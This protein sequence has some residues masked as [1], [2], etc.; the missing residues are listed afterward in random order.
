MKNWKKLLGVG[1][2]LL[3]ALAWSPASQAQDNSVDAIKKRG[4]LQVGF[5]S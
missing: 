1:A 3:G 4:K 5:G 2:M